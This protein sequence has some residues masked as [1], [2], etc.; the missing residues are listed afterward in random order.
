[1]DARQA[2]LELMRLINGYQVSQVIH[3]AASFGIADLL[4][5]GP[6][7]SA[8][9]AEATGTDTRSMH[10]LLR[11]LAS[12]GVVEE[13]PDSRFSLTD[14]G[15]CLRSDS[16]HSRAAW[17]C[18]IGRPYVW[19]PWGE[20]RHSVTTGET[21]FRHMHGTGVWDWRA[22]RPEETEIFDAAMTELSGGAVDAISDAFDFSRFGCIVDLGGGQGA[23]LA[24]ILTRHKGTKGILYDLPHVVTGAPDVLR[25][26]GVADRCHVVGGNMFSAV[27]SGGDAYI[28]KSVLMDEDDARVCTI[29]RA[30]RSAIGA[31]GRLVVIERL[32]AEPNRR[33]VNLDIAMLVITGGRERTLE[34]F[35]ALFAEAGFE[36]EKSVVTRSPFT[37]L[38]GAPV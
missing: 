22:E 38:V 7:P 19:Q 15:E 23:L 10:R 34:E 21:A 14:I 20:L 35:S 26:N 33:E 30:C 1:M 2:S 29:L 6:R 16:P 12:A 27:P 28:L 17:A 32:V 37:M 31:S 5:D 25:A 3:V 36:L 9:I 24:G 13:Q 18:Y 11:A 4:K 8:E